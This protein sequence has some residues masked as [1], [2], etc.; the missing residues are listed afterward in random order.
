MFNQNHKKE[1]PLLGVLGMGGGVGSNLV[2]GP[3]LPAVSSGGTKYT[4]NNKTIHV[5]TSTEPFICPKNITAE[6]FVVG[7]GGGGATDMAGGGGA[8]GVRNLSSV[9]ITTGIHVVTVGAGG[10]GT[11]Q[12]SAT[13]TGT[14]PRQGNDSSIG[15]IVVASGGG[16]GGWEGGNSG[17]GGS[18]GGAHGRSP[19]TASSV[20]SPDGISPTTQG[21]DGG[22][23]SGTFAG[24]AG[25]G[26]WGDAG[27]TSRGGNGNQ[28]PATFR[29][30]S[31]PYGTPGPSGTFYFAGGGG[32]GK[33]Q[34][35]GI[36]GGYGGGG[37][38]GNANPGGANT[39]GNGATNT[40]GGGGGGGSHNPGPAGN[41]GPGIVF[42]AYPDST[43]P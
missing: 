28:A 4:Y 39:A 22:A 36:P 6:V 7:G 27:T 9:P 38:G 43:F 33:Y 20:A 24:G 19:N 37:D 17:P 18:G 5:F 2:A 25:G 13:N 16:Y 32:A 35:N 3:G 23:I 29:D 40:G 21:N 12:N 26:G 1:M 11:G 14:A 10:D 8:G 31:N 30:P 34:A 41:G 42:I 15:S